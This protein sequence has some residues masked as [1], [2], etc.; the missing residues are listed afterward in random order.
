MLQIWSFRVIYSCYN[1]LVVLYEIL[2]KC[3][4]IYEMTIPLY[5]T[6][7]VTETLAG[8]YLNVFMN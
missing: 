5:I 4:I 8:I 1:D 6:V 2:H 7:Y 3:C